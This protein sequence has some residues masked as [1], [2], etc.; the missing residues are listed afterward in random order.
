MSALSQQSRWITPEDYLEGELMREISHEYVCGKVYAMA[1]SSA[2]HNRIAGNLY[3][4]LNI[5]LRGKPCEAFI[6]DMKIR[7]ESGSDS[8]FYYPGVMVACDPSDNADYF[9]RLPKVI[10]EVLSPSTERIDSSEKL[11]AYQSIPPVEVYILISQKEAEVTLFH[12]ANQW[13]R[14]GVAGVDGR[15]EIPELEF[16]IAFARLYERTGLV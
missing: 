15:L 11:R 10:V 16:G 13:R 6:N 2:A 3:A 4:V 1:E 5:H 9:R 14:E 7:M 8:F 12:R